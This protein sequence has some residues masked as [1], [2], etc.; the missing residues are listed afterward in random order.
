MFNDRVSPVFDWSNNLLVVGL[1]EN[2]EEIERYII[3]MGEIRI[4]ERIDF[5]IKEGIDVL[6]CAG[7]CMEL[8]QL[9]VERGIKVIP[10]ITGNVNAVI[11]AYKKGKLVED[12]FFMPGFGRFR[13]RMRRLRG[14][15]GFKG[16][17]GMVP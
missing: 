11:D 1:N 2:G 5:L 15:N 6:I 16:R 13:R 7:I 9:M 3:K 17:H 4:Y 10:G 8:L 12:R 14:I